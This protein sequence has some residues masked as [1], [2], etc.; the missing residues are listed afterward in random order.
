MKPTILILLTLT[1]IAAQNETRGIVPEE[2]LKAR[3]K[4]AA[5]KP[6]VPAPKYQS[7][8]AQMPRPTAGKQVGVTFWRLRPANPQDQGARLLVQQDANTAAWIPERISSTTSLR[9]GDRVRLTLESPE[10]GY[11]YVIDRE[12]YAGGERGA[13]YLIFP[14]S[15]TRAGDN[16]VAAGKLI[17]IPGQEDQPNFFTMTRSR[18]DQVEEEITVLLTPAPL[19][20][21]EIG[22]K[23]LAITNDQVASWEKQWARKTET[24]EL[25]GGTGKTWT[26]AEQQAAAGAARLLTQEDPAPQTVY[27]VQSRPGEPMLVKLR[28]RYQV[29]R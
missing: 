21:L 19:E 2:I 27:R 18:Q 1:A 23:A 9:A 12:R 6:N 3:V 25:T 17:D 11:L 8:T 16:Q 20:G 4:P 14:T 26:T 28:L 22:A 29:A 15:R 5:P 7:T 24:F 10:A 13:P